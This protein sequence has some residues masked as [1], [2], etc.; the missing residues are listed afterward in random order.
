MEFKCRQIALDRVD[1]DNTFYRISTGECSPQL[2]RSIETLGLINPPILDA[3]GQRYTIITG[4][5]RIDAC[6]QI[7]MQAIPCHL[8]RSESGP[9]Q[10]ARIAISDNAMSR[11]LNLIEQANAIRLLA[12]VQDIDLQLVQASRQCGLAVNQEMVETLLTVGRMSP[13]LQ[14]AL[15]E[16]FIALP[17]ALRLNAMEEQPAADA[18]IQLLEQ[19]RIGL[20]RQREIIDWVIAISRRDAIPVEKLLNKGALGRLRHD[21]NMDR[22]TRGRLIRQSIRSMRYP[23][24]TRHE[25]EYARTVKSMRLTKGT[26]LL[27]PAN[28]EGQTYSLKFDFQNYADLLR[29][30]EEFGRIMKS[31]AIHE[32]LDL[33]NLTNNQAKNYCKPNK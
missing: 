19:L 9:E 6:R 29:Q 10:R 17:V 1:G 23:S 33:I 30:R 3:S 28:F 18:F 4:F 32:L 24:I 2:V 22:G 15:L 16:G 7:G 11:D 12:R 13:T 27:A 21:G 5:A 14:D 20:N 25:A 31:R 8:M 26:Q